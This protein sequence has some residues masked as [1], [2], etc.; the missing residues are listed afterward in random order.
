[1]SLADR[2]PPTVEEFRAFPQR[3]NNWGRWGED[4]VFGTLNHISPEV[5]QSAGALVREGRTV[6][7]AVPI[8]K[9]P[10]RRNPNP[11]QHHMQITGRGC[12]DYI[13]LS[14]HGRQNTHLDALCH[15]FT[16][17]QTTYNGRPV[18]DITTAG[19][20]SNSVDHW[21]DGIVT[22]AVLYD[23]PR[24]RGVEYVTL[25]QPVHG[26]EL[27]DA[28]AAQGVEPR[29]GDA[30]LIRCGKEPFFAAH[31]DIYF[32]PPLGIFLG[33]GTPTHI[34]GTHASSI[35]FL[36][37]HDAALM[38]WDHLDARE[39]GYPPL[40]PHADPPLS[41]PLHEVAIPYMGM[42]LIDNMNLE[43]AASMCVE[44]GRWEFMLTVAPLIIEGG[45]GSPVNPLAIF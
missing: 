26:W 4:D 45:T 41:A 9:Q 18:S 40:N 22:R 13:G 1:M 6:S 30:V 2:T 16:G 21:R 24:L 35:E 32:E 38:G 31:P 7:L 44:L 28:A 29:S 23:I 11:A 42:P 37:E 15:V 36:Y 33:D 10:S 19:A 20:R 5:R 17:D 43:A 34:P 39:Q 14:Y 27:E 8:A 25:D 12:T 3:F